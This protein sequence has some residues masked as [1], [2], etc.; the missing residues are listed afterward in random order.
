MTIDPATQPHLVADHLRETSRWLAE[1]DLLLSGLVVHYSDGSDETALERVGSSGEVR[2]F[3]G[4]LATWF[5]SGPC[6]PRC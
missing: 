3:L 2:E 1:V 5:D 4:E 6:Q